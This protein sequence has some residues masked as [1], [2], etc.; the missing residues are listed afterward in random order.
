MSLPAEIRAAQ[1]EGLDVAAL[2]LVT[3]A[4]STDHH[5][6]LDAASSYRD[7][8]AMAIASVLASWESP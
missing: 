3:N 5:E 6:V 2:S 7:N 8:I 4:G 1:E